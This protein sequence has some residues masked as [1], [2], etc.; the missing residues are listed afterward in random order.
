[1]LMHVQAFLCKQQLT[2]SKLLEGD[3]LGNALLQSHLFS[4]RCSIINGG[5]GPFWVK[6]LQHQHS[7]TGQ[8]QPEEPQVSHTNP[9]PVSAGESRLASWLICT[10]CSVL[11]QE[12]LQ[13][14]DSL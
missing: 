8:H 12:Q 7:E 1:M 2:L 4:S 14:H 6:V 11:V 10:C 3:R 5:A 9:D 13:H